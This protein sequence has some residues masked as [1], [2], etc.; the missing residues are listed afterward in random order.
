MKK[1]LLIT[2]A[3]LLTTTVWLHAQENKHAQAMRTAFV[4]TIYGI[5]P[6]N[7]EAKLESMNEDSIAVA[8]GEWG[9]LDGG[10]LVPKEKIHVVKLSQTKSNVTASVG[11]LYIDG[12]RFSFNQVPDDPTLPLRPM[13]DAFDKQAPFANSYYRYMAGDEQAKHYRV[14]LMSEVEIIQNEEG[15]IIPIEVTSFEGIPIS[16][17]A[18]NPEKYMAEHLNMAYD[19][20]QDIRIKIKNTD[21]TIIHDWF[22]DY[23]E[24]T[25]ET[26]EE[27]YDIVKVRTSPFMIV[28]WAMQY[29]D[30]V[31]IMDEEIRAKILEEIRKMESLYGKD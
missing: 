3:L 5:F 27:G 20:P 23:Y 9:C 18:W 26:C 24:K 4:E 29:G 12:H 13:L 8:W 1:Q 22:G 6:K 7:I 16:N 28:H 2:T 25:D 30:T 31:E 11:P 10:G 15:K 19:E 17:A 14:D 21:Y